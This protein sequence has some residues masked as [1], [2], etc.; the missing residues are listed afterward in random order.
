MNYDVIILGAGAA[1]LMCAIEAGR[2]GR[3]VVVLERNDQVGRKTLII[4]KFNDSLR[5]GHADPRAASQAVEQKVAELRSR[6]DVKI[7][8]PPSED[9]TTQDGHKIQP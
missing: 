9:N 5:S 4:G 3:S 2:R 6:S 7:L 1:G 8:V